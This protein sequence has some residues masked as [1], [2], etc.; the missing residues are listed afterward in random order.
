MN[1]LTSLIL[2]F[3]QAL[4]P[5]A[6]RV[7]ISDM[8]LEAAFV[9]NKLSFAFAALGLAFKFR[10]AALRVNRP[11]GIAFA[12]V[13]LAAVATFL[14]V[15][16]L[17]GND[18]TNATMSGNP[19]S[20]YESVQDIAEERGYSA[21]AQD[22]LPAAASPTAP[23]DIVADAAQTASEPAASGEN[24]YLQPETTAQSVAA[25]TP[26]AGTVAPAEA[27]PEPQQA[28]T[29]QSD[30][31]EIAVPDLARVSPEAETS[32]TNA[33]ESIAEVPALPAEPA[34]QEPLA[35]EPLAQAP[36][37]MPTPAPAITPAT[38]ADS[39]VATGAASSDERSVADRLGLK[40]PTENGALSIDTPEEEPVAVP[41]PRTPDVDTNVI[42]TL[43]RGGSVEIKVVADTLLT[44]Y[45]DTNF[46]GSP[47]L[48]RYVTPGETFT[49]NTPFSLYT[50]NAAA[51]EITADGK[52]LILG[53]ESEEQFRIFSKP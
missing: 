29:P 20:S 45:R 4:A 16:N 2:M 37:A 7:W 51:I 36:L 43:V 1:P 32:P 13:A 52:T 40:P 27:A 17:F 34:P 33:N 24:L 19:N 21:A 10:V 53:E 6:D 25:T 28:T 35:Q 5:K 44:L 38:E 3:A 39:S 42:S 23:D 26:Q 46:S 47:R 50:D 22:Q 11:V 12:S 48:N 14:V 15:P 18:T 9:P 8:R 41:A 30:T 31:A 49:A